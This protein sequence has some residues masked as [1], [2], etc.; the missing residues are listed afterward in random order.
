MLAGLQGAGKTTLAGKLGHVAQGPG[1]LA[2]ARR[3]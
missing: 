3:L 2:A 1:A